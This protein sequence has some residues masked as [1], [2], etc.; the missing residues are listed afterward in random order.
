MQENHDERSLPFV[1]IDT[2]TFNQMLASDTQQY[3]MMAIKRGKRFSVKSAQQT[4]YLRSM[5]SI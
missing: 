2:S 3:Q 4:K 5:K 1:F